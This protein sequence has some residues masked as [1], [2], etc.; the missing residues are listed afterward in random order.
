MK[1]GRNVNPKDTASYVD[2]KA[3]CAIIALKR[4]MEKR[5]NRSIKPERQ[6]LASI[7]QKSRSQMMAMLLWNPH[8]IN[9]RPDE[10]PR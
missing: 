2:I 4:M 7:H 10:G 9:L 6:L 1:N 8:P 3:T 5:K